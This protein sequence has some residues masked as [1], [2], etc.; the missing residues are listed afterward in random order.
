MFGRINTPLGFTIAD[1]V[2]NLAWCT[3]AGDSKTILRE[4]EAGNDEV[5]SFA[6][7]SATVGNVSVENSAHSPVL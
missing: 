3:R 1:D 6:W 4:A 5:A 7:L 2:L